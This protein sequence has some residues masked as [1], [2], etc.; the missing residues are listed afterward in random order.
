MIIHWKDKTKTRFTSSYRMHFY[1]EFIH[2]WRARLFVF[3]HDNIAGLILIHA[4]VKGATLKRMPPWPPQQKFQ[5]THPWRVRHCLT[6]ETICVPIYFNPRTREG[7]D[8]S[9]LLFLVRSEISIH[10]PVKGAT[11]ASDTVISWVSGISIHAPVKG[12]T[13]YRL[14]A[15]STVVIFQSTHPWRVRR[16]LGR[17]SA[18]FS[19]FQSTHPWRVRQSPERGT[20]WFVWH[21]NPRTREGCDIP[22]LLNLYAGQW[23]SIHAPVKGATS[24]AVRLKM[25][26]D[27]SIHAPVKGATKI[28]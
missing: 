11:C 4:P 12:A 25:R 18:S 24:E 15:F 9:H 8:T 5:S 21:F 13:L 2:L 3:F 10:A 20:I 1:I 23:I 16:N 28:W 14:S 27:I 17:F 22:A 6:R 7:C 26:A 19:I